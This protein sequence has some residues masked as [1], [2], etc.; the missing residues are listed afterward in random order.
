[1]NLFE[2]DT[3]KDEYLEQERI[4]LS[5]P[6]V[7]EMTILVGTLLP[8]SIDYRSGDGL[9][10][11]KIIKTDLRLSVSSPSCIVT[12]YHAIAWE[13]TGRRIANNVVWDDWIANPKPKA[14]WILFLREK[15]ENIVCT[16]LR[17]CKKKI[18]SIY[19]QIR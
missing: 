18:Q 1:M 19:R 11:I 6:L 5:T 10:K 7:M 8:T 15:K 16:S 9:Y 12:S 17:L 2:S 13:M 4:L 14:S 3:V